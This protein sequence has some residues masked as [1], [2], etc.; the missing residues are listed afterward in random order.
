[1]MR[2]VRHPGTVSQ[3][4]DKLA[5]KFYLQMLNDDPELV[6][7]AIR[8]GGWRAALALHAAAKPQDDA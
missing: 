4:V 5:R 2:Q 7:S 3:V 6:C 1:M 8:F